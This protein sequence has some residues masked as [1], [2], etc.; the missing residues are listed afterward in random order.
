MAEPRKRRRSKP[1]TAEAGPEQAAPRT[2]KRE[3]LFA[4]ATDNYETRRA[5]RWPYLRRGEQAV[6]VR[7]AGSPDPPG[8]PACPL[9]REAPW[10]GNPA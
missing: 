10:R 4:L 2:T 8:R 3:R 9:A 7:G 6:Q 5:T 1:E